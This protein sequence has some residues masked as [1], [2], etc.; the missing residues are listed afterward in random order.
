MDKK[1]LQRLVILSLIIGF[2]FGLPAVVPYVGGVSLFGLLFLISP[3]T[4]LL[5]IMSGKYDI[6][7]VQNSIIHGAIT[8][9]IGNISYS[10]C[11][12]IMCAILFLTLKFTTNYFL[13]AM[14]INS[15]V[16]LLMISIIFISF[17]T[18][19]TNAFSG[20]VVHYALNLIR[21]LYE[22]KHSVITEETNEGINGGI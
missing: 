9:F 3:V 7:T 2:V 21:D 17:L 1:T 18:A 16:W 13:T 8:G 6:S 20:F 11:Y 15:P 22:K 19:V 10:F 12:C 14:I 5:L 4:M